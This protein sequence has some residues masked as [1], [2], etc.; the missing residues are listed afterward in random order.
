[1]KKI[2]FDHIKI[3][4]TVTDRLSNVVHR[5]SYWLDDEQQRRAF[6][7]RCHEAMRDGFVITSYRSMEEKA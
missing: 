6:G 3:N 4:F 7:Q 1:M 2:R 5:G